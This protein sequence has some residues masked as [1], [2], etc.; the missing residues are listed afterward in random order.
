MPSR[1]A[2]RSNKLK[3]CTRLS[4]TPGLS[5]WQ[6]ARLH[7]KE[8]KSVN[9]AKTKRHSVRKK[10]SN[11]HSKKPL[12]PPRRRP[13][14]K[15]SKN[16]S[17]KP[18]KNLKR[19]SSK[20]FKTDSVAATKKPKPSKLPKQKKSVQPG[21]FEQGNTNQL[22]QHLNRDVFDAYKFGKQLGTTGKEGTTFLAM[23]QK[24]KQLVAI[25]VFKPKKSVAAIKKECAFQQTVAEANAAP[26]IVSSWS[27]D[28]THKCF[29]M[30][31]MSR[32]L[33]QVLKEQRGAL[34][35]RQ[36]EDIRTAYATMDRLQIAHNDC[37]V[38]RNIMERSDGKLLI[39]DFGMSM[40]ASPRHLKEM[41]PRIN[42]NMLVCV[43][44]AVA[45]YFK[46]PARPPEY[47]SSLVRQYEL[48][49]NVIVDLA[50]HHKRNTL[51]RLNSR[52]ANK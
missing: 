51:M 26:A 32:T 47:F 30:E 27:I 14:K 9:Q 45:A 46:P 36:V 17:K 28:E 11:Q 23:D 19:R 15:L 12:K 29:A 33:A 24:S 38:S 21:G 2:A 41:G 1:R 18:S 50:K 4:S 48:E 42:M 16:P 49:H 37:N 40:Q 35:A 8:T 34:S 6:H 44:K 7:S 43:D 5:C 13:S 10:H 22:L 25:K 39:I 52:L 20:S 3:Q 31:L